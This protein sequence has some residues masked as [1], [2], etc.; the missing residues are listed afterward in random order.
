MKR[1]FLMLKKALNIKERQRNEALNKADFRKKSIEK[2]HPELAK[3]NREIA[4]VSK[5]IFSALADKRNISEKLNQIKT[6]NLELQKER[7]RLLSALNY[8][9]D[10]LGPHFSCKLCEDT[11]IYDGKYCKCVFD[12]I[13]KLR[14]EELQKN[15]SI[16][17]CD[18][19]SF[20]IDYYKNL[21]PEK[22]ESGELI[23]PYERMSDIFEYCKAWA[24]D[25]SPSRTIP[26]ILMFGRT[27]LGKTHLSLAIARKVID[28][29]YEV[30]YDSTQNILSKIEDVK[31]GRLSPDKNPIDIVLSCDLLILDDLG[32]EFNTPFNNSAFYNIINTRISKGLPMIINTNLS[33]EQL[34]N[35]Y[36]ERIMSR[37]LGYF[38]F[39]YFIGKDVRQLRLED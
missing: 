38:D 24:E 4:G 30:I 1:D 3:L 33:I 37:M 13:K 17:L 9:E 31:F 12:I 28:R 23:Q 2:K 25:F 10:V 22:V 19:D 14:I 5:K 16:E 32:T 8:S 6:E 15:S 20:N 36:E 39:L 7:K 27:G 21:P 18:F 11:G 34:E 35:R 29:G 26:N